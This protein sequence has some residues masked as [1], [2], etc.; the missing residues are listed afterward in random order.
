MTALAAAPAS[1]STTSRSAFPGTTAAGAKC[2]RA[3]AR[4][5]LP[6]P[7]AIGEGHRDEVDTRYAGKRFD[8]L[9]ARELP[10]CVEERVSFM[11]PFP[12]TRTVTHPYAEIYLETC[13]HFA[14]PGVSS[15]RSTR[16]PACRFL[17]YCARTWG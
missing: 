6:H 13:G 2:L 8:K 12:L 16:R 14:R 9:A 10:P 17:G 4:H 5:E 11:A 1:R 3:P 15:S 7:A